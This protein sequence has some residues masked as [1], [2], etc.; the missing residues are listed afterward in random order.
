M[1]YS[2]TSCQK[3]IESEDVPQRGPTC[4]RCHIQGITIGFTYG[5]ENFHGDTIAERQRKTVADAKANGINAE[6]VGSR[7]V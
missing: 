3:R 7:W 1:G 5:K 4:F 2:C 6:P